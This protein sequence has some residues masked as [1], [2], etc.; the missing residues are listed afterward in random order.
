MRGENTIYREAI[1]LPEGTSPRA[2]GKQ[3]RALTWGFVAR[4]IP[5]CAGKTLISPI[6][7]HALQEHPRVRGE[8]PEM[9]SSDKS[10]G[11]T[12]PRARGKRRAIAWRVSLLRNIPACAGK[13]AQRHSLQELEPEHPRVRGENRLILWGATATRGTSPRARGKLAFLTFL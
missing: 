10:L 11:G 6:V 8:N 5:A 3:K 12:S 2:R 4:N 7:S 1:M 9:N 13:T